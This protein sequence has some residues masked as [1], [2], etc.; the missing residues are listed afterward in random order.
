MGLGAAP[1]KA[2]TSS[3]HNASLTV[4]RLTGGGNAAGM[5]DVASLTSI[6]ANIAAVAKVRQS[7]PSIAS[8]AAV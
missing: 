4:P 6:A 2:L 3:I 1:G 8:P 5:L 7:L